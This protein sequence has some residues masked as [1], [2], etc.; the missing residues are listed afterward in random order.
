MKASVKKLSGSEVEL[1]IEVPAEEF[2]CFIEKACLSLGKDL[3]IKGFRK[4][5]A[6]KEFVEK[7]IGREKILIEAANLTVEENYKKAV[8]EN[9]IEAIFNPKIEIKKLAQGTPFVFSAKTAVLPQVVLPDYKKI[10]SK[11]KKKEVIV[12]DK[13]ID[14][15]LKWLQKSRAKFSAKN[16]FAQKDNFVEIEYSSPQI[17]PEVQKDAFILGQGHFLPGFEE[18]I[19]GMKPNNN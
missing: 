1:E 2:D 15:A 13:E 11:I 3:N 7:E 8:L 4:G 6:P 12:E 16:G 14:S 9:K 18:K 19:I 17:S 5:R 10:A